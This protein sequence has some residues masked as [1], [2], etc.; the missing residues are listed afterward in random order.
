MFKVFVSIIGFIVGIL[1]LIFVFN[2]INPHSF[3]DYVLF[4]ISAVVVIFAAFAVT[5]LFISLNDTVDNINISY[6]N[7]E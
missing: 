2:S 6:K 5:G 4:V 3:F 7:N 1:G